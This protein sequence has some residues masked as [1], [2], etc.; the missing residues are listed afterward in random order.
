MERTA[1]N[2]KSMSKNRKAGAGLAAA[3]GYER[4]SKSKPISLSEARKIFAAVAP[5]VKTAE[6]HAC[7]SLER[8]RYWNWFRMGIAAAQK[9]RV[10]KNDVRWV[11]GAPWLKPETLAWLKAHNAASSESAVNNLK[12]K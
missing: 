10:T 12:G 11:N 3:S 4:P 2:R 9:G 8:T 6:A 7:K 1:T 5:D